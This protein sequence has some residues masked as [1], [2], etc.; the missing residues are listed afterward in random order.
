VHPG[1]EH[2][3]FVRPAPGGGSW[4]INALRV[5]LSRARLDVLHATDAAIGLEPVTKIAERA[6]ALAAINGG[7]FHMKGDFR[8]DSSGTLQ[9]DRVLWSEP[10]RARASVGI[11]RDGDTDRLVFGHVVWE[12]VL[13]VGRDKR[14]VSGLNRERAANELV[15]FTP[16]FG[17]V[18]KADATGIE[19]VVRAGRVTG[20][21]AQAGGA[22]I[23]ADGFVLSAHGEAREW[24]RRALR[25][26]AR[27]RL[28]TKLLPADGSR[29]NPWTKAEDIVGAGP[30]LVTQ[31]R[32]DVTAEREKMAPAFSTDLHP[33][34][35]IAALE[36]GRALL[37]VADGRH[38]PER[39]GLALPDL[40][41][42]LIE[43]GAQ[44]AINL[45]GGGSTTL[46]VNG[47]IL[48]SPSDATGER[49]VSDAIVV[50]PRP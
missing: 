44:E 16:Q 34:T 47:A 9:I 17:P 33:R 36:D 6:R 35:A 24:A 4:K 50:R 31:G 30:K 45:D 40:A 3:H 15:V 38:P 20:S 49:P 39:V 5:D 37:L 21:F 42:L 46:V 28:V 41:R 8:G 32:V 12:A 7:Y 29:E 25:K 1:I 22:A 2:T 19:V 48:N 10:D 11:V 23:P 27:V 26:G 18:T 43:L 13:E 14:P